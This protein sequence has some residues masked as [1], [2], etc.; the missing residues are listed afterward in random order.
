MLRKPLQID[1]DF[2]IARVELLPPLRIGYAKFY[3]VR[4]KL[5]FALTMKLAR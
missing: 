4:P 3:S 5:W 1:R 2:G